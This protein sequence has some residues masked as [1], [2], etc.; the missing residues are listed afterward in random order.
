GVF[1]V[2]YLAFAATLFGYTMWGRLLTSNA[3]SKVAPLTLLVP[4]VGLVSAHL[5]LGEDLAPAQWA[6]AVV[7]MAG[8][9]VNVF[10]NR[11]GAGRALARR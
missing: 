2:C 3:A 11:L 6:G 8:L 7:V 9:L 5:L 10:G 1:A 4:V